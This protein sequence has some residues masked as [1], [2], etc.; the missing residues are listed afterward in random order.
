MEKAEENAARESAG[1]RDPGDAAGRGGQKAGRQTGYP[2]GTAA[3]NQAP[4]LN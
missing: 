4:R 1:G 3:A 2:Q